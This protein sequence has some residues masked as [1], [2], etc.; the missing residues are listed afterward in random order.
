MD[1][2]LSGQRVGRRRL[3]GTAGA[4]VAT[5]AGA[6]AVGAA[7][8][9]PAQADPGQ[10]VLQGVPNNVGTGNTTEILNSN[11]VNSTLTLTNQFTHVQGTKTE[12]GPALR[13]TPNGHYVT[14]PLGSLGMSA[15][16]TLWTVTSGLKPDFFR[17]GMNS[18]YVESFTPVRIVDTRP[19][20]PYKSS[21]I[22]PAVLTG[23]GL[24]QQHG[25]LHLN[26]D[27]LLYWGW[28][29]LMNIAVVAGPSGGFVTAY[30]YGASRP[31]AANVN[32]NGGAIISNFAA[33]RVGHPAGASPANNALSIY[34]HEPA[35]V[36]IDI[37]AAV[38]NYDNDIIWEA[39]PGGQVTTTRRPRRD[40]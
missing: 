15:D 20:Q 5:V 12:V 31:T 13:L 9:S 27:S 38:V 14:G 3:L 19:G 26:L 33:V 17:T 18:T 32:F 10:P 11:S 28:T 8:G 36:I 7:L 29:V 2:K 4:L 21:I 22:N 40:S 35:A 16:G 30:P 6:G 37:A 34:A 39:V 25:V 23:A 24:I 1:E